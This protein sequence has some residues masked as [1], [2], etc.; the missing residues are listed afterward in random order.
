MK[1][2]RDKYI[3]KEEYHLFI[4]HCPKPYK[5]FWQI[6]FNAGLRISEGLAI[7]SSDIMYQ[8]NKIVITTLKRKG[9]PKIPVIIPSELIA[10][11]KQYII[12]KNI[13]GLLFNFSRQFAWR[14]FKQVC[15]KAGLNSKYSP[16]AFRHGHGIMIADLTNGNMIAIK[17]RLRHSS[18]HSTE[19]YVHLS[20]KKQQELANQIDEYLKGGNKK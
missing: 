5:L 14:V 11:L 2:E 7:T 12:T 20:E 19:F 15:L 1:D 10:D 8:E 3:L 6:M 16:H 18:T 9:N 4:E 17:N 13:E